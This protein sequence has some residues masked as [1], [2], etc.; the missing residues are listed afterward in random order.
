MEPHTLTAATQRKIK[1]DAW[2]D[3]GF[4]GNEKTPFGKDFARWLKVKSALEHQ[5]KRLEEAKA[6]LRRQREYN[7]RSRPEPPT[8][9]RKKEQ[10]Q[11][12]A[13]RA[14]KCAVEQAMLECREEAAKQYLEELEQTMETKYGS[15]WKTGSPLPL[16]KEPP[17]FHSVEDMCAAE[18][19]AAAAAAAD[20]NTGSV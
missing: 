3:L 19:A 12:Q 14:Q 16:Q 10:E 11:R 5:V 20:P 6:R 17:T 13:Q 18:L 7:R 4:I 15:E 2:L 1:K 8:K 9:K